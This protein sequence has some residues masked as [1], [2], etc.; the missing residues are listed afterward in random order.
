MPACNRLLIHAF[1]WLVTATLVMRRL[2]GGGSVV[3]DH[4]HSPLP[5]DRAALALTFETSV[6]CVATPA[7]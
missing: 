6:I 2:L 4:E 5:V 3:S 7:T 1:S